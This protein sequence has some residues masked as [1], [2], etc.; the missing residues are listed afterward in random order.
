M[1]LALQYAL[2]YFDLQSPAGMAM[3]AA[4]QPQDYCAAEKMW[5]AVTDLI[6]LELC[7]QWCAS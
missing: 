3:V 6:F 4:P 5:T 1:Q 7:N 2:L